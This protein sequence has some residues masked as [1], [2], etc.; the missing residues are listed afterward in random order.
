M[1]RN[2]MI[3]KFFALLDRVDDEKDVQA[4]FELCQLFISKQLATPK[5][6]VDGELRFFAHSKR[7]N[8]CCRCGKYYLA[9]APCFA[10]DGKG[11]H[12]DCANVEEKQF[13][14]YVACKKNET[15]ADPQTESA[16]PAWQI[17]Q[18]QE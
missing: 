10:L 18:E 16:K 5:A 4:A 11:W 1:K 7:K 15:K 8:K 17:M 2:K 6:I 9:G 14:Y 3:T 12:E 13:P